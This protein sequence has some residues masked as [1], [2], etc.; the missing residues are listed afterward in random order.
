MEDTGKRRANTVIFADTDL[1]DQIH[2]TARKRAKPSITRSLA[3]D[4]LALQDS[5]RSPSSRT[6]SQEEHSP[7]ADAPADANEEA[8]SESEKH[9]HPGIFS[10]GGSAEDELHAESDDDGHD[11]D[12]HPDGDGSELER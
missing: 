3:R 8:E 1:D 6:I 4:P 10:A 5:L 9:G 2:T 7:S 11:L 12:S